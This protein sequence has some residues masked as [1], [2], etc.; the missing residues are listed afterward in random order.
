MV[1]GF[2]GAKMCSY[3]AHFAYHITIES[4]MKCTINE[5]YQ[6]AATLQG[7]VHVM[8]IS[9]SLITTDDIRNA[10]RVLKYFLCITAVK[11]LIVELGA[12]ERPDK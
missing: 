2:Q 10:L 4:E 1:I 6:K 11:W 3:T 12:V 9:Q 7:R 5:M 8:K